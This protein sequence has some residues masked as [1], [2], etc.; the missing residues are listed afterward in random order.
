MPSFFLSHHRLICLALLVLFGWA[1]G[2]L[3]ATVLGVSLRPTEDVYSGETTLPVAAVRKTTQDLDFILQHNLFD[4]ASRGDRR[5]ALRQDAQPGK[6]QAALRTELILV[7]TLVADAD[8]VA[9][10]RVGREIQLF[11]LN[12]PVPGGGRIEVIERNRVLIR[13]D[14]GTLT[15]LNLLDTES[16]VSRRLPESDASGSG[17]R[18]VA[19]NT[20]KVSRATADSARKNIAEQLRLATME[21]RIVAGRTDGFVIKLLNRRSLLTAMGLSRGDV[22]MQVNEMPL[23]SPEKALQI[24][25]QLRE[26]RRITLNIERDG[27]PLTLTYELE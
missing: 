11:H 13:A 25:Q 24:M 17:I 2:H 1:C 23:D 6:A 12:G 14:G 27:R 8:S 15:E 7:G 10:I 18:K 16:K 3:A 22:V 20:W 21:P 5:V 19:E 9:L 4:P 26:A